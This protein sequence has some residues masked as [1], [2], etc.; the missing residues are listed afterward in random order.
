MPTIHDRPRSWLNPSDCDLADFRG[1]VERTTNPAEV[2]SATDVVHGIPL[3]DGE[4][5]RR[6]AG[7]PAG[8]RE[9]QAELVRVLLDG[10]GIVV[11]KRA[12]P[13]PSVV[14]RVTGAFE[15]MI[16]DQRAA[17]S[18]RGD[19]YARPGTNDRV[20]NAV[21]KLALHDP[22]AFAE[23][24]GEGVTDLVSSAWLGPGYQLTS[25]VNVVNPGAPAQRVHRDY[26][27]GFFSDEGAA[28]FPTH[29][30]RAAPSLTLQGA[31]AHCD[32]PVETGPTLYLPYSQ[33]YE[34]GYLAWQRPE[35]R[36]YFDDHHV[37]MP[38]EKG[39]VVFFS[40][41][42][43]HAAGANRT[44]GVRR[45]ANLLQVSS[46]FGRSMETVDREAMVNAVY[47]VL[48]RRKAEGAPPHWLRCVVAA[49]A[50]GYAFP[51]NLDLDAPVDG[52]APPSQA[53]LVRRALESGRSAGA[54]RADLAAA[55][56]RRRSRPDAVPDRSGEDDLG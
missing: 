23:Y 54:L 38:L 1:H 45:M 17:G 13:D 40:P 53:D 20:W 29:V 18:A 39:D 9:I 25:Q 35:F 21:E 11:C 55:A 4:L 37:Q 30:H 47:P 50:E 48:L 33:T 6:R 10:P 22:E 34:P 51:T 42:L 12:Y 46:P 28:A 27:F 52:L 2:P 41:A 16:A 24:H 7:T 43:F 44:T 8:R 3:Y 15:K 56:H 5:L 36:A 49:C 31:V 26:H 14:D 32:M 19:H